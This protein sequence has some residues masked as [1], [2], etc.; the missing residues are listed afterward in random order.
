MTRRIL[1]SL[2]TKLVLGIGAVLILTVG[3][4]GYMEMVYH[5][6]TSLA[7]QRNKALDISATVMKSI[8]YPMLDGEMGDVQEILERVNA[9]KD[10]S[11]LHLCDTEGVIRYSGNRKDLDRPTQSALTKAALQTRV[12]A[13][14]LEPKNGKEIFRYAAPV[15]NEAACYKCHGSEKR[16]L[17]VFTVGFVWDPIV[18]KMQTH[19][20]RIF[21]G[22]LLCFG[23][24]LGL[25]IGLLNHIVIRPLERLTRAARTIAKGD[26]TAEIAGS[27]SQD[28]VGEL[29]N[30]FR[31]MQQSLRQCYYKPKPEI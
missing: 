19:R 28:E 12:P 16:I 20:N 24:I 17:G 2:R 10:L 5:E 29:T 23:L 26:I 11:V 6:N 8:E 13:K 15:K 3:V 7:E 21:L 4:Y 1:S 25:I 18:E 22:F 27:T 30:A 31:D 9:L 14:G